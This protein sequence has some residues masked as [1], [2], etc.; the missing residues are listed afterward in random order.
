MIQQ[1]TLTQLD[2]F[3]NDPTLSV[4]LFSAGVVVLA[5]LC[6]SLGLFMQ[7]TEF[8]VVIYKSFYTQVHVTGNGNT[9]TALISS[10][11][12]RNITIRQILF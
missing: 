9:P 6:G 12:I 11:T 10:S 4:F 2:H 7:E 3:G 5:C 1:L 8:A